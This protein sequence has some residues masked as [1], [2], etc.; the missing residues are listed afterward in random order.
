[1][2]IPDGKDTTYPLMEDFA[3]ALIPALTQFFQ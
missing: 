2:R 3:R 1:V